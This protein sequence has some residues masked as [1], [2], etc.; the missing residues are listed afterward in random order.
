MTIYL[1]KQLLKRKKM[2]NYRELKTISPLIDFASNDYLGLAKTQQNHYGGSTGSRLLTGNTNLAQELEGHIAQF[3]GYEAGLLFNCGYMA[4]VGLISTVASPQDHIIFDA[5]VHASTHDGILL[6]KAK[7][8][9]FRHNDLEHLEKRLKACIGKGER[10]ICIE[11]IYST[12]GSKAILN[13]IYNL[14]KRYQAQLIIDEAHA[15]GVCGPQ[16][17]GLV[18][19]EAFAKVVT[20]G[21]ALGAHGAIVLGSKKLIEALINFSHPFIYT[22]ALPRVSLESIKS[23]YQQFPSLDKERKHLLHLIKLSGSESH[24][25]SIKITGNEAVKKASKELA[26][27][28]FDVRPLL[29]PTVRRGQEVLRIALHAFNTEN[30]LTKLLHLLECY[31]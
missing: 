5:H 25:F 30:E 4:N 29:S 3:H 9:P 12:D 21:K 10:F 17:G 13:E 19:F 22:T 6:S 26:E 8:F 2:G 1:E 7:A 14:A 15:V 24:I 11:S 16:G 28:G 23:S 18:N 20:F 27:T 31:E